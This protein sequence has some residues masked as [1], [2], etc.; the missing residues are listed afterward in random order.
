MFEW[1]G[2]MWTSS[3]VTKDAWRPP[4]EVAK[5]APPKPSDYRDS[6]PD[7]FQD[8]MEVYAPYVAKEGK[9]TLGLLD[10]W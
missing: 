10:M 2:N 9:W 1:L 8:V 6:L 4:A 3:W 7:S 5:H